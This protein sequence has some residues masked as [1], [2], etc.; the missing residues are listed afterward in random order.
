ML[1]S[2]VWNVRT[3]HDGHQCKRFVRPDGFSLAN[4]ARNAI[5]ALAGAAAA[6]TLKPESASRF[7]Q[8][9]R[10]YAICLFIRMVRAAHHRADGGMLESHRIRLALEHGEGVWM[11]ITQHRQ[12]AL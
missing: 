6:Q 8:L 3:Q 2:H 11:H 12:V 10:Y 1:G 5:D 4:T 7:D 9:S